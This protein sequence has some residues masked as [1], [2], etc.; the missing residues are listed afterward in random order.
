MK[1]PLDRLTQGLPN[2]VRVL[3]DWVVTIV[4]AIVIVLAV[5][6]WVINPYRI[7]FELMERRSTARSPRSAVWPAAACSTAPTAYS[8]LPDLFLDFEAPAR[9]DII[10][11]NSPPE[12]ALKCGTGGVYVKRLIGLPGDVWSEKDGYVYI[13][14]E[15]LNEPYIKPEYRDDLTYTARKIPPGQ[16]FMM[17]DNRNGSC[18]SR[19]WGT[20]PR[21]DLIGKV[22]AIYWPPT[23]ISIESVLAAVTSLL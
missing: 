11:F 3:I 13:N 14:G 19:I 1:N 6:A 22:V 18:D 10:V 4:G 21:K 17:G 15:K 23:R 9:G 8:G 2:G 5:K 16:Y 20:V 12:A 7:P